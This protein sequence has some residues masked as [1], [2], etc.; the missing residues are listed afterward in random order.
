M[1]NRYNILTAVLFL[2]VL[3]SGACTKENVQTTKKQSA[4]NSN[5]QPAE[6]SGIP[7]ESS[8]S[9]DATSTGGCNH[10]H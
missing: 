1:K 2:Y 7:A 10:S 9:S 4:N 5:Q 6:S 8:P 3:I